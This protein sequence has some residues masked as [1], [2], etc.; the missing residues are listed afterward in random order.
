M[1]FRFLHA[2][3]SLS[4]LILLWQA[5][6]S[7]DP[8]DH[9]AA[10]N[11]AYEK[12][13]SELTAAIRINPN[14]GDVYCRRGIAHYELGHR[15]KALADSKKA[16]E[17]NPKLAIAYVY[18]GLARADGGPGSGG[19]D[20]Y[21]DYTTA[22]KLDSRCTLAYICRG[23]ARKDFWDMVRNYEAAI[24]SDPEAKIVDGRIFWNLTGLYEC[25]RQFQKEADVCSIALKAPCAHNDA[26]YL[27]RRATAYVNL[28]LVDKRLMITPPR[29]KLTANGRP[30]LLRM[31]GAGK[32]FLSED[33]TIKPSTI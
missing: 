1:N 31:V 18:R 11:R 2:F 3:T 29:S 13:I 22:I 24:A 26:G 8:F 28:G 23:D 20:E 25:S 16:V 14:N 12:S 4:A 5:P 32:S 9:T 30:M 10:E 21:Q 19:A 7:A 15:Q 6:V 27:V 33:N 17:L